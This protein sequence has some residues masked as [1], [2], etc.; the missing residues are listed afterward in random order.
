MTT[1]VLPCPKC[2]AP[3][4]LR[5]GESHV[6]CTGCG[7]AVSRAE[8]SMRASA[9]PP[10]E[11][12]ED[13]LRR[14]IMS[15]SIVALSV[16]FVA[17][18]FAH[19][20]ALDKKPP[21]VAPTPIYTAP[22]VVPITPTPEGEIAWEASARAPLIVPINGDGVEDIFGFF[23]VWDGRS[24]WVPYAG[25]FDGA[26]LKLLWKSEPIDP[27]ILKRPFLYPHAL[28]AGPRVVVA[29]TS[30]TLRVFTLATGEKL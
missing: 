7:A 8:A 6:Q 9:F 26:T 18:A 22:P 24:A 27:Q 3:L 30:G 17:F 5:D 15:F 23:R 28:V 29:D 21:P 14:V 11:R 10:P 16:G 25:A 12:T 4:R 13:R 20:R 1:T 2:R 19:H